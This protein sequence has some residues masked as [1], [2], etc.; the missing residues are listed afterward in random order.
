MNADTIVTAAL[1]KLL[2]INSGQSPTTQQL[3]DGREVLND[4]VTSWSS[5]S[6]MVYVDEYESISIAANTQTFTMGPSGDFT[7]ARPFQIRVATLKSGDIEYPMQIIDEVKYQNFSNKTATGQPFRLYF[8]PTFPNATFYFER[9]TDKAYTLILTSI[10]ELTEFA[11][12]TTE[13]N[14]PRYYER[15]YKANLTL[16]L[17]DEM[18]AGSRVT[19]TMI[20][21]AE[22]SKADLIGKSLRVVPSRTDIPT[23]GKY[24][25][26]A[27]S[28]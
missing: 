21:A 14:L 17:A 26:E 20:K 9:T 27:D 5:N 1:R 18:G 13:Y 2:V 10:K 28:Y 11:D 22:E 24:N 3:S 23:K 8:R 7:N 19:P 12:G 4:L 15:A 16:E 25:I 6:S